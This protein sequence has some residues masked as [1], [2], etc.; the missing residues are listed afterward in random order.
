MDRDNHKHFSAITLYISV[1]I[2]MST[3]LTQL[4][5]WFVNTKVQYYAGCPEECS[6][7]LEIAIA[8]KGFADRL[9]VGDPFLFLSHNSAIAFCVFVLVLLLSYCFDLFG[10][11]VPGAVRNLVLAVLANAVT[12]TFAIVAFTIVFRT[13]NHGSI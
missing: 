13:N 6:A 1:P 4:F 3:V 10:E 2:A 7:R 12:L 5:C 8:M 9:C 11:E